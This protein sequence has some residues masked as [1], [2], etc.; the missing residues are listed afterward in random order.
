MEKTKAPLWK[1]ILKLTPMLVLAYLMIG[2]IKIGSF[3]IKGVGFN[4]LMAAPLAAVYACYEP[5]E[6]LPTIV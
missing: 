1:A 2:V 5:Y 4:I 6:C 3:E